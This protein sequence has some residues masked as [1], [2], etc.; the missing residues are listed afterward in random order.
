[1]LDVGEEIKKR[2]E[3]LGWSTTKL[4]VLAGISQSFLSR[5]ERNKS[6][7]SRETLAKISGAMGISVDELYAA[8]HKGGVE[9]VPLGWRRIPVLNYVQARDWKGANTAPTDDE[10]EYVLTDLEHPADTFAIRVRDESMLPE[11][12]VGDIVVIDPTLHPVPGDCVVARP[13]TGEVVF[14]QYRSAGINEAGEEAFELHPMNPL[15]GPMRSD[16]Q[17]LKI[18]GVMVEHRRYRRKR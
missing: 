18:I 17:P 12:R 4:A 9:I 8:G 13:A 5:I 14:R 1:M 11:F 16:R 2:R 7:Y 15:Y 3:K 10:M 6:Y